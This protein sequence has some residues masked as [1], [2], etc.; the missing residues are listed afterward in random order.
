MAFSPTPVLLNWWAEA[1]PA[2][3][4]LNNVAYAIFGGLTPL[5]VSLMIKADPLGPAYYVAALCGLSVLIGFYLRGK[6]R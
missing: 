2:P 5:I 1:D 6:G 4:P 3:T